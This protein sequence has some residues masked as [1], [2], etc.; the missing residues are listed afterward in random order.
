VLGAAHIAAGSA[1]DDRHAPLTRPDVK[2][3]DATRETSPIIVGRDNQLLRD[4]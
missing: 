3:R 1:R 2:V 4:R